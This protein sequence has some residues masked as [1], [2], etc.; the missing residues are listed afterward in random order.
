MEKKQLPD[1]F[2]DFIQCLNANNV[3]YLLVGGWAVG[4]YGQ[5][6]A[7]KDI[8]FLVSMD[9]ENLENLQKAFLAFGSPPINI[10]KFREKGSVIRIG[11]SPVQIEIINRADGIDIDDCFSR[12]MVFDV[13][14]IKINLISK[15]D[16][17][18]NKKAS[19]RH[20]DLADVENLE[21]LKKFIP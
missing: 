16:L 7:T 14:G 20:N 10:E 4:M 15:D 18:T 13:D 2:K 8:D 19:G 21:Y 12:K 9:D 1:D 17:I 5:P 6:R 11:D 3:K